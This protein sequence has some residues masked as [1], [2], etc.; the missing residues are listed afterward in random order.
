MFKEIRTRTK[1]GSYYPTSDNNGR[2]NGFALD[3]I[4]TAKGLGG[5]YSC[6]TAA[7]SKVRDDGSDSSILGLSD[8]KSSQITKT[9]DVTVD[10]Q[11]HHDIES[12]GS[13]A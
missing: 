2:S 1:G 10:C 13:A 5:K 6:A 4:N 7:T 8:H 9:H 11:P 12:H 3:N